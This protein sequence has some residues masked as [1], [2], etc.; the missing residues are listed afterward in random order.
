MSID[1]SRIRVDVTFG[2][3]GGPVPRD[4]GHA[5][6][7]ALNNAL[8]DLHE[9]EWLAVM[10]LRGEVRP[11]GLLALSSGQAT[12]RLRVLPAALPRV[13]P[14]TGVELHINGHPLRLGA[15]KIYA[16]TPALALYSSLV[17]M[18]GLMEPEPF[19]DAIRQR[20]D[21][22]GVRTAL[23]LGRRRVMTIGGRKIVGFGVELRDL[24]E[25]DSLLVQ[26]EGLGGRQ[27]LG[28]GGF[29]PLVER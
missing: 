17:V 27:R 19:A 28:C 14:L 13:L 25:E 24:A 10:P 4:H 15:P 16:L 21:Q 1:P 18:T 7:A 29:V 11:D 3:T 2:A 5:L 22:L 8:G 23:T 20:L 9:A 12:L 26:Y 6:F